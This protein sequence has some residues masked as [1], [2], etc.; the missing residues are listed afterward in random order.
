MFGNGAMIFLVNIQKAK[1]STQKAQRMA[2]LEQ[3]EAAVSMLS[4]G[5]VQLS[6]IFHHQPIKPKALASA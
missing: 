5:F 4:P 2:N 6:A 1:R 3:S